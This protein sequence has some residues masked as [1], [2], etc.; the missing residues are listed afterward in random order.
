MKTQRL[1]LGRL[2]IGLMGVSATELSSQTNLGTIRGTTLDTSD[3]AIPGVALKLT[4]ESS[5]M[6]RS[7]LSDELGNYEFPTTQPGTYTIQ[8]EKSGSKTA[9][10]TGFI[11]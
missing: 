9:T 8:A 3:A 10:V 4:N 2:L 1:W 11:L 5:G 6:Q 7:T